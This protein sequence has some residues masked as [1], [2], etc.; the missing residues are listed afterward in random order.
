[1]TMSKSLHDYLAAIQHNV[2]GSAQDP[3]I[4]YAAYKLIL[5]EN[6]GMLPAQRQLEAAADLNYPPALIDLAV[7]FLSGQYI[8]KAKDGFQ[9]IADS[10][11]AVQLLKKAADARNP[12]ACLLIASCC[13]NGIGCTRS[14]A[15]AEKYINQIDGNYLR[16]I[17]G[18]QE[19][20]PRSTIL[21]RAIS[22]LNI[23]PIRMLYAGSKK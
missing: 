13:C 22:L 21:K 1:M 17:F 23:W 7:L 20:E 18:G 2:N 5:N 8:E 19:M 14:E 11:R 3:K 15:E 12:Q 10:Q 16:R 9:T 6:F 4:R